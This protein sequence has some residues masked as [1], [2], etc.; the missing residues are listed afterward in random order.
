MNSHISSLASL[1]SL[2]QREV[3]IKHIA[4]PLASFDASRPAAE[5]RTLMES[6]Y[7]DVIG[8]RQEGSIT[9]YA[10]LGELDSGALGDHLLL[11]DERLQVDDTASI[12]DAFKGLEVSQ[13]IFVR[14]FGK[15]SGIVTKGDLRKAPIRIWI[16]GLISL[17][18]M[19]MLRLVREQFPDWEGL[20]SPHRISKAQEVLDER[21][22]RN[23]Q[24]DVADCLQFADKRDILLKNNEVLSRLGFASKASARKVLE[25]LEELRD[26]VAHSQDII[27]S[28][29]P[30]LVS[31]C[32]S[33]EAFIRN[34]EQI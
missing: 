22:S 11:L 7:F 3:C 4:E 34:A 14:T 24:I 27:T 8:V 18:E 9:G 6:K 21:K 10:Q 5:V 12:L 17:V 25:N 26:E 1:R 23:E 29:W 31:L 2:F 16:F 33:G 28:F 20:L 30:G 32:E 19:H 13:Q 15:V